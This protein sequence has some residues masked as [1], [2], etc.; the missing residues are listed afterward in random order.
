M[1]GCKCRLQVEWKTWLSQYI[2][3]LVVGVIKYWHQFVKWWKRI[4]LF[5]KY[6]KLYFERIFFNM[7]WMDLISYSSVFIA[8]LEQVNTVWDFWCTIPVKINLKLLVGTKLK[9]CC[10]DFCE[11]SYFFS[12]VARFFSSDSALDYLK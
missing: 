10:G 9:R 1:E 5:R 6:S 2:L 8:G 4:A 11:E 3:W 7:L 12:K